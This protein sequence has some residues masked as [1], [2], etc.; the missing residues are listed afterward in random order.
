MIK[1]VLII[2]V[3]LLVIMMTKGITSPMAISA[4]QKSV[5]YGP[6]MKDMIA[7]YFPPG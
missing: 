6:V 2:S 4:T 7:S 1:K 5:A 3:S